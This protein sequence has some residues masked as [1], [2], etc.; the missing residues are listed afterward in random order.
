MRHI[1]K[2]GAVAGV[3]AVLA[4]CEDRTIVAPELMRADV[5]ALNVGQVVQSVTGSGM[6]TVAGERRTFT[7]NAKRLADGTVDGQF[8][9]ISR[10]VDRV[11]H[12]R[13]V[14]LNVFGSAAWIG[15]VVEQDNTVPTPFEAV[16]RVVDLAQT[17]GGSPDLLSL[18]QPVGP[19][20]AQNYCNAAPST[21]PLL[22]TEGGEI[23]VK[24]PGSSSFTSSASVPIEIVTFVPCAADG[25]GE[26]VALSGSLH[27]LSHFTEDG[28]GGFH[29]MN[30]ANPQGVSGTGLTTGDTYHGTGVTRSNFNAHGLPFNQTFVNNFRIIGEEPGNNF[31]VHQNLHITVNANGEM[32]AFVDNFRVDCG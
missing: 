11:S 4:G 1:A 29:V 14:C 2:I 9:V 24:Q 15:V 18:L 8:Q 13:V 25:A 10:Q 7:F 22:P 6:L 28:A 26:L 12:G 27:L 21:P 16:F 31:M 30:E 20:V 5:D 3:A 23:T 32:T 17:P 19:G